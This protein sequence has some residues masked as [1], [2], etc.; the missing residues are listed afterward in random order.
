MD[1]SRLSILSNAATSDLVLEPYP[2]L[3]IRNALD[4]E[5]FDAL[6]A[7]L[8]AAE[9]I[10]DGREKKDTWFDYPACRVV[11]NETIAP[12]WRAFFEYHT[13][14]AFFQELVSLFGNQ[15]CTLHPQL[16]SQMGKPLEQAIVGM[17]PGGR[18]DRLAKGADVSM[19]CQFYVNYTEHPRTVRGSHV[20]RP[21]ELFAA[22][23]Y[24]RQPD[25]NS[26]GGDLEVNQV[27]EP[28]SIFPNERS[29]AV[30]SLPMELDDDKLLNVA[31]AKYEANTLVL[32]L[33]SPRSIHAVSERAS[34]PI[35][36]R[37]INFCCDLNFDLFTIKHPPRLALKQTLGNMPLLWRM[38]N[39]L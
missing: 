33:N 29:I 8:P 27:R 24:F 37:H 34:T 28:G 23:L 18:E 13:S 16:E 31:T 17:R 6:Q 25:D 15:I 5:V 26:I 30:D 11:N 39:W 7:T 1:R 12:L 32:F 19:E 35:P 10:L 14:T 38:A 20:D 36:R 22:L 4:K 3:I 21:S 2:H 9:Q